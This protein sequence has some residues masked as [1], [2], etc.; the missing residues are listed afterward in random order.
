[1]TN[2][3]LLNIDQSKLP[4]LNF[5]DKNFFAASSYCKI[6]VAPLLN[7]EAPGQPSFVL[8]RDPLIYFHP[9]DFFL[10]I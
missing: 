8:S 5:G 7:F 9:F 2:H 1:M 4:I 6:S 10:Q 3:I